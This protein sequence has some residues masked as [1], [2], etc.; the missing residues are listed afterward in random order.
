MHKKEPLQIEEVLK[1]NNQPNTKPYLNKLTVPVLLKLTP[2]L[3][4]PVT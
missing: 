4:I 3:P 2:F 1:M